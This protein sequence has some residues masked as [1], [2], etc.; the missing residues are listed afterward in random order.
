MSNN[1][2]TTLA[3][4]W[5]MDIGDCVLQLRLPEHVTP[6]PL[7]CLAVTP[8]GSCALCGDAEG[9]LSCWNLK[10]GALLQHIR[11]HN[12]RCVPES[13]A[14]CAV[15]S[16]ALQAWARSTAVPDLSSL[17]PCLTPSQ[18]PHATG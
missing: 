16:L 10:T 1:P 5:D 17:R 18:P 15:L 9:W 12:G 13:C 2:V 11:A 8:D 7:T 4:V 3:Q 6:Q 14:L